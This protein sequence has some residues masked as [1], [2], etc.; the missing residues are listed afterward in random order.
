[1]LYSSARRTLAL[2][3][4][5]RWFLVHTK[6]KSERRA[7]QQLGAQG[8]RTYFPTIPKTIHHARQRSTVR[9]P[10]FP[11][12]IFL[13]LDPGRDRWLSVRSTVGVAS[14]FSHAD[15]PVPVPERIVEALIQRTDDA[16]LTLFD[17]ALVNGPSVRIPSGWPADVGGSLERPNEARRV[18]LLLDIM[19]TAVPMAF[20]VGDC[21]T[22]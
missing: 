21:S 22:G 18:R 7:E 17:G 3:G 19:G 9:A 15:R 1:M 12:Y 20:A 5:E 10:L 4:N 11:R 2:N 13:I 16:H 8:F 14:L 6:P